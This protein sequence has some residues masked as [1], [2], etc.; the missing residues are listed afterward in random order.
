MDSTTT[1]HWRRTP[2]WRALILRMLRLATLATVV[3]LLAGCIINLD[4]TS[5]GSSSGSGSSMGSGSNGMDDMSTPEGHRLP[6]PDIW[7]LD[8]PALTADQQRRLD[9]VEQYLWDRYQALGW[10]IMATTQGGITGDIFDWLDPDSVKGAW[11]EPPP[12]PTPEEM[13]LPD[14]VQLALTELDL[15]PG[16]EGLIPVIRPSFAMYVSGLS[17]ASS[18]ED[19]L[20]NYQVQ[21][22]PTGPGRLYAGVS[23][24]TKNLGASTWINAFGGLIEPGTLSVLEM[25]VG[26]RNMATKEMEMEQLVGIAASRDWTKTDVLSGNFSDSVVRIQVEFLTHGSVLSWTGQGKGGWE[27]GVTIGDFI[28]AAGRRYAPGVA[29]FPSTIGGPQFESLY[30]IQ[31]SNNGD[32]WVG[33]NGS[34]LGRYPAKLWGE[35]LSGNLFAMN[36]C[37]ALWYGEVYDPKATPTTWTWTDMASGQ[38]ASAG[39]GNAANFRNPSYIDLSRTSQWPATVNDVLPRNDACYTRSAFFIGPAPADRFFYV[40]GPGGDAPKGDCPAPKTP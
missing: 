25:A 34:W 4:G 30:Q 1:D 15:F 38:F 6:P 14:G 3:V 18:L 9:E 26:C 29:I 22:N 5:P 19:Y 24:A 10:Q 23:T 13:Q 17:G 16:P 32:W 36:A 37:E 21:G 40:G 35:D 12:L 28:P 39:W 20:T 33:W 2:S 7:R 11:E 27:G 31:L 8:L